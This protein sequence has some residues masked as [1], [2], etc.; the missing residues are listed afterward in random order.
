MLNK[1]GKIFKQGSPGEKNVDDRGGPGALHTLRPTLSA[2]PFTGK[3]E[4][5]TN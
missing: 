5:T 3:E 1:R 2:S 4:K